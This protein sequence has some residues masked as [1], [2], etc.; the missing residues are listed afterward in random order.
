FSHKIQPN[1]RH[2]SHSPW[3][4]SYLLLGRI[5]CRTCVTHVPSRV[6]PMSLPHTV[7]APWDNQ[8]NRRV[9]AES[10]AQFL[11]KPRR[12]LW[13]PVGVRAYFI[14]R[15]PGCAIATLGFV[16]QPL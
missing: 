6:L 14:L 9:N 8:K 12:L 4:N 3:H 1:L 2:R 15:N 5:L 11:R 16:V 7:S 13:N 10:V